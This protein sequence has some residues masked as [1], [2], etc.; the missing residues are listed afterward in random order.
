M[1]NQCDPRSV[2]RGTSVSFKH[3][4]VVLTSKAQDVDLDT[5][6]ST[7]R[8][9]TNGDGDGNASGGGSNNGVSGLIPAPGTAQ[10]LKALSRYHPRN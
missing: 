9:I 7:I 6:S 4:T 10:S 8:S 2:D 1:V 3:T 5:G